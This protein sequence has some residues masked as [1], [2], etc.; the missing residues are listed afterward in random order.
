MIRSSAAQ[1]Q[2]YNTWLNLHKR[3]YDRLGSAPNHNLS[4]TE[5]LTLYRSE[6][7]EYFDKYPDQITDFYTHIINKTE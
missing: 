1:K 2:M 6:L 4:R 3:H 7:V 5:I